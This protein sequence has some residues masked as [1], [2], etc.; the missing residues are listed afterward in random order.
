MT[1]GGQL[2]V[3]TAGRAGCS[4][5]SFSGLVGGMF[6][7]TQ[8]SLLMQPVSINRLSVGRSVSS[9]MDQV[10]WCSS[11]NAGPSDWR[12]S[13]VCIDSKCIP[14][15]LHTR[16]KA[17]MMNLPAHTSALNAKETDA[18][19]PLGPVEAVPGSACVPVPLKCT[20]HLV[21]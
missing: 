14:R 21:I 5:L 11:A 12:Q 7:E 20:G 18:A 17:L 4:E 9:E 8:A 16:Y 6:L 2:G 13:V 10:D 15:L 1:E 19:G 3:P